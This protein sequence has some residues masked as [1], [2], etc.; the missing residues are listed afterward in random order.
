[1]LTTTYIINR[2]PSRT[3]QNKTPYEI[4]LGHPPNYDH[5]RVFGCLVYIKDN[6]MGKDKFEERGRSCVF[7][8]YPQRQKGYLV[9]DLR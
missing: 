3:I 9:Y 1:M 8:G 4:L 5:I 6:K 7:V 2:L